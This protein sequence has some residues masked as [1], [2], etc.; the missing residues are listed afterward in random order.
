MLQSSEIIQRAIKQF[1]LSNNLKKKRIIIHIYILISSKNT[2]LFNKRCA[3][4][5]LLVSLKKKSTA[6][7]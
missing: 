2:N 5:I 3:F 1:R 7:V 6:R 4:F